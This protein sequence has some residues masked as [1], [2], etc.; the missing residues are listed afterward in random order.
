MEGRGAPGVKIRYREAGGVTGLSRGCDID[1]R[2]LPEDEALEVVGLVERAAL[3]ETRSE[4]PD[5]ARDL[6]GYE[7][8]IEDEQSQVVVRFD[9]ATV[10]ASADRL[11]AYLQG[12][13]RPIPLE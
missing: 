5:G 10:P 6:T 4:G 7:I 8:V 12:R 1:T 11:L 9:D 3:K 2:S 13:A